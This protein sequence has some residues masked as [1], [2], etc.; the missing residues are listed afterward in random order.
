MLVFLDKFY[1]A[2]W[3]NG[4]LIVVQCCSW[5]IFPLSTQLKIG[6]LDPRGF[7]LEGFRQ[8]TV[9]TINITF[10]NQQLWLLPVM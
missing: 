3:S 2:K 4:A 9:V 7:L 6:D 10:M 8:G 1:P 5:G